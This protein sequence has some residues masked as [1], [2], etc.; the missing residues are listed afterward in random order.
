MQ[1]SKGYGHGH[2]IVSDVDQPKDSFFEA[3]LKSSRQWIVALSLLRRS[4]QHVMLPYGEFRYASE[5]FCLSLGGMSE[6][7]IWQSLPRFVPIEL[8]VQE[9]IDE[10]YPQVCFDRCMLL[11]D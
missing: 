11:L 2:L 8:S 5:T 1:K 6:T 10:R 3:R 7:L 4:F 9:K